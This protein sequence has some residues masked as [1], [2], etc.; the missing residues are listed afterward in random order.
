MD[1]KTLEK[2]LCTDLKKQRTKK[3]N[4]IFQANFAK[5]EIWLQVKATFENRLCIN[6]TKW[7]TKIRPYSG[8][9]IKTQKLTLTSVKTT[10]ENKLLC[11]K[12]TIANK[13]FDISRLNI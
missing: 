7:C 4:L 5:R 6:F 11:G 9:I 12:H 3:F 2:Y 8:E 13:R 1:K 10:I